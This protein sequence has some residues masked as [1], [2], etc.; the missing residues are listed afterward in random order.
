M[1]AQ[2]QIRCSAHQN[3]FTATT[4]FASLE[5]DT[6]FQNLHGNPV[7]LESKT[8]MGKMISFT[9]P[10]DKKGSAYFIKANNESDNY[11]FVFH[12]RWGLNDYIKKEAE[13]LY[14]DLN[15]VNVLAIDLYD[16]EVTDTKEQAKELMEKVDDE[17]AEDIIK[18]AI[19]F[20][21]KNARISTIGWGFG[22]SWSLE[23]AIIAGRHSVACVMYYGMPEDDEEKL[24]KL[25]APVLGIFAEDDDSITPAI[26]EE[27]EED[28]DEIEK[29]IDVETFDANHA[30]A[31][32]SNPKFDKK[33]AEKA[34][35]KSLKF[36]KKGFESWH[37]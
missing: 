23:A 10:D 13:R 20:A 34:Y 12:D 33:A 1:N 27:F 14:K 16:G 24:K 4:K 5:A 28:M 21:S 19:G 31:N 6:Y 22:G 2:P 7:P 37:F 9:T 11:L 29:E 18:G 32:P 3:K 17:T 26:V 8:G 30:F 35:R 25:L 36:I 15:D